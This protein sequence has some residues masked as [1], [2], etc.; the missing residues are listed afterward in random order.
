MPLELLFSSLIK[1]EIPLQQLL[2]LPLLLA[3]ESLPLLSDL[4][5]LRKFF[6]QTFILLLLQFLGH[7]LP[8]LLTQNRLQTLALFGPLQLFWLGLVH[9]GQLHLSTFLCNSILELLNPQ[10]SSWFLS[11]TMVLILSK[12]SPVSHDMTIDGADFPTPIKPAAP[13]IDDSIDWSSPYALFLIPPSFAILLHL[14]S[15]VS[16]EAYHQLLSAFSLSLDCVPPLSFWSERA[17]S[18]FPGFSILIP[19]VFV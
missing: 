13:P 14:R 1:P 2:V 12:Y 7:L 16:I 5:L 6:H 19:R 15:S 11:L 17:F 3:H 10:L 9:N 8:V 4:L 18:P